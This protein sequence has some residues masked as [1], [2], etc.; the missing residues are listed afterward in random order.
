MKHHIITIS[1][2]SII[3]STHSIADPMIDYPNDYRY[4]TH[5]KSMV[6][7]EGHPLHASFGGMHHIY[8]NDLA[9][10][11]YQSGTFPDGAIIIFDLLD[12]SD[13]DNSI[14]EQQRKVLGVMQKDNDKFK[15]T[16][17]WGFEGFANGDPNKPVIG[18]TY[19]EACYACHTSQKENDYV[20]SQWRE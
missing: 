2:L 8:A 20:F 10:K 12:T 19:K 16:A 17:G 3:L 1:L 4:W 7:Q 6:I 14:T 13:A 11:G 15:D 18:N 5:V 9:L